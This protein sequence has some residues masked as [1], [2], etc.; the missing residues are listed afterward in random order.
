MPKKVKEMPT[1]PQSSAGVKKMKMPGA[2]K[3]NEVARK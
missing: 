3:E 2:E 1:T